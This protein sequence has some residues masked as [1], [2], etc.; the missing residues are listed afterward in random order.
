MRA[1]LQHPQHFGPKFR[2]K[3]GFACVPGLAHETGRRAHVGVVTLR[4]VG[5]AEPLHDRHK[6][7]RRIGHATVYRIVGQL[8]Q[9]I[10]TIGVE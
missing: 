4:R 3:R 2:G 5:T 7:I 10:A 8:S 9:R 6:R 1:R